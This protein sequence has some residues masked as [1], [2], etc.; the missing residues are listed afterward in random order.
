MTAILEMGQAM[1]TG[2]C[3]RP[4]VVV[5][6]PTYKKWIAETIG[7]YDKDGN[8]ESHGILP[9]YKD[10]INDYYNLGVNYQQELKD[11]PPKDYTITFISYEGLEQ[12]GFNEKTRNVLSSE[13]FRILNQGQAD[14]D[15]Q[16]LRE[17]IDKIL[18]DVDA[19]KLAN[20]DDLGFD[21][22]VVDEA[23]NF[24][25]IFTQVK[26]REDKDENNGRQKN[27]YQLSSGSPSARGLKLFC[28]SQYILRNNNMRNVVL[29][30]ATPFTNSPL[31]VYSMLSLVAY[32]DLVNRGI[33]N[34]IDFFDKFINET[35]ELKITP[36]GTIQP[37][38]VIKSFDN[39]IV[40]QNIIFNYI[41]HRTGE[42]ANVPRPK[43]VVYPL[44]KDDNGK[45]LPLENQVDTALQPTPVQEH[46]MKEIC[47]FASGEGSVIESYIPSD[48]YDDYDNLPGR[49]LIAINL[50]QSLTLS[51]YL[52]TINSK[53]IYDED[54]PDYKEFINSSPKLKYVMET[55]K[56][57]R[58]WHDSR[59][60]PYSN[61][62][63]YMNRAKDY[64]PLIKQYLVN[65]IGY[66]ENE[67]EIIASGIS[68]NKKERIKEKFL[69]GEIKII[70][71]SGTIKEGIDLQNKTTVLYVCNLDWNPTDLIQVEGRAWRQ[72]NKHSHVRV[73]VPMI[74]NS[75]D[76]L[77]FQKL[78]E[79]TSRLNDIWYRGTKGNVINVDELDPSDLKSALMTDPTEYAKSEIKKQVEIIETEIED[80]NS[81]ISNLNE[82]KKDLEDYKNSQYKLEEQ[83]KIGIVKLQE[84]LKLYESQIKDNSDLSKTDIKS[85]ENKVLSLTKVLSDDDDTTKRF[86]RIL[87][88]YAS[89]LGEQYTYSYYRNPGLELRGEIDNQINRK[90]RLDRTQ[91]LVLDRFKM[92]FADDFEPI[93]KEYQ[94]KSEELIVKVNE[95]KS[96]KYLNAKIGE[97]V[98]ERKKLEK[99]SKPL[100]ARVKEFTKHNHLLSCLKDIHDCKLCPKQVTVKPKVKVQRSFKENTEIL[101]I[102]NDIKQLE[103]LTQIV[104]DSKDITAIEND[105]KQ[106]NN[107]IQIIKDVA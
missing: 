1:Y 76:S 52:M 27:P 82:A 84:R 92:T 3:K 54:K 81:I 104:A 29:L 102:K 67:V 63:I 40:L 13:L 66:S 39:R 71:G 24:K 4:L 16:K 68:A 22:I 7:I 85:L 55:I 57:V 87:R 5:P 2:Q 48:W 44:Y 86:F 75:V 17:D 101:Q 72:G 46:Y 45:I 69:K 78:D 90:K 42:E 88:K 73:V 50:Q 56:T 47:K 107:L 28:L 41:I 25:K 19:E 33:V 98:A 61:Q 14:R 34:I 20:F 97:I 65:V 12:L 62:I 10:R 8:C 99:Y 51:P 96:V 93:I 26:G 83:F 77:L 35:I 15:T 94:I 49:V 23:H 106:L 59:N 64:F 31:E 74:E 32:Q 80:N 103:S 60:E 95:L 53:S 58:N 11:K 105:I 79:K 37:D 6:N 9:Q 30:T 18:G 21:Y 89:L 38:T 100:Q 91:T 43:K 70:I 36:Q